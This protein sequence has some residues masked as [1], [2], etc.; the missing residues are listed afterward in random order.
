MNTFVTH[1]HA[2]PTGRLKSHLN[3]LRVNS[4]VMKTRYIWMPTS[5]V[6]AHPMPTNAPRAV[7]SGAA[8]DRNMGTT[9]FMRNN[10]AIVLKKPR[11]LKFIGMIPQ[12]VAMLR[13]PL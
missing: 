1:V 9:S 6:I 2:N 3:T 8:F 10:K 11:F 5:G 4:H 13:I 12:S 7:I